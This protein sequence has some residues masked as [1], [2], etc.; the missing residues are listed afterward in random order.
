MS[1]KPTFS[2]TPQA[3]PEQKLY[4]Y[5]YAV[6]FAG[7]HVRNE[8]LSVG[9]GWVWVD[10]SGQVFGQVTPQELVTNSEHERL[11][12]ALRGEMF[13]PLEQPKVQTS[14]RSKSSSKTANQPKPKPKPKTT[15]NAEGDNTEGDNTEGDTKS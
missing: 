11:S 9:G 3:K 5:K 13:V 8:P 6:R 12:H 4:P 10:A 15:D 14:T 1:K 7:R 2:K